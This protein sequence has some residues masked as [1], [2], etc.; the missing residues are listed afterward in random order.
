M[1]A[2]LSS[3]ADRLAQKSSGRS[4]PVKQVR[5]HLVYLNVRTALLVSLLVGVVLA[6]FTIL[7]GSVGWV[8]LTRTGSLD[9]LASVV[10][11]EGTNG[12]NVKSLLSFNR[13]FELCA[14]L[15]LANV[16]VTTIFGAVSA[17]LY[18]LVVRLTGGVFVG[19]TNQ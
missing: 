6:A 9:Q 11:G 5:L 12:I 10:A 3:I 17:V 14:L 15:G 1:E 16:V 7:L 19:F 2:I 4:G 13:V 18:N 8:V